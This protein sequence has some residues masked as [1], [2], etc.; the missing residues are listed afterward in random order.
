[1]KLAN[2]KIYA[3]TDEASTL[4]IYPSRFVL[5]IYFISTED[6]S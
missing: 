4:Q 6:K 1:L 5:T 3:S 2:Q